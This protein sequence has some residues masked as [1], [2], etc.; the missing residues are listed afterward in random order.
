MPDVPRSIGGKRIHSQRRI[1]GPAPPI[2][3]PPA[4]S[5][6]IPA[7]LIPVIGNHSL[8][9]SK[10]GTGKRTASLSILDGRSAGHSLL[11][12]GFRNPQRRFFHQRLDL[13]THRFRSRRRSIGDE[14]CHIALGR[15]PGQ[16]NDLHRQRAR[17]VDK[18]RNRFGVLDAG[19]IIVR[20][21]DD[22][23][24]PQRRPVGLAR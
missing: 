20:M 8:G 6:S 1:D 15:Q 24:V 18:S 14:I 13:R 4:L 10:I 11:R 19:S 21:N 7:D 12:F 23:P 2:P 22:H 5:R 9:V 17:A 16:R 3:D